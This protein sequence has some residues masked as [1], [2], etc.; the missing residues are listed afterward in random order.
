MPRYLTPSKICLLTLISVYCHEITPPEATL[1][2]L[3]FISKRLIGNIH[4]PTQNATGSTSG[5][6]IE[7]SL[8]L[9]EFELF[10]SSLPN[11][12]DGTPLLDW[13]NTYLWN[14]R[15]IDAFF[16][17]FEEL[18]LLFLSKDGIDEWCQ[19]QRQ[20]KQNIAVPRITLSSTSL[21]GIF[22]RRAKVE[23]ERLQFSDVIELWND[24]VAYRGQD[25]PRTRDTDY[26]VQSTQRS[27]EYAD[28][29]S[30]GR[31][32]KM[33]SSG[34]HSGGRKDE[35]LSTADVGHLLEFQIDTMQSI[36]LSILAAWITSSD[37]NRAWHE[38][39]GHS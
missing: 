9:K 6:D 12:N 21:L 38:N 16:I 15:S 5:S 18:D 20:P 10:L 35:R 39:T 13:Y 32:F 19:K 14:A 4:L 17:I 27:L 26:D 31:I 28:W 29:K 22:V 3:T 8:T 24:F 2:I 30:G 1:P 33:I 23:F 7:L 37:V 25:D 34:S 36:I 11:S